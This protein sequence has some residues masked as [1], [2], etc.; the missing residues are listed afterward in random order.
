MPTTTDV[1]WFKTEFG[2]EIAAALAGTPFDLDM[3]TALACQETGY[4]WATLRRKGLARTDIL[5]LCV[6]DTLDRTSTFPRDRAHLKE[7]D[8]NGEVFALA[9]A[10]LVEMARYIPGYAG[11][12]AKP[13]KFCKGF[14]MFQYDMQFLSDKTRAFFLGGYADFGSALARCIEEL[15]GAMKRA[16]IVPASA[17][18]DMDKA[19]IAIAYN[20]GSYDR[21]RG[22]K[23]GYK[24]KDG[25]YYGESYYAYLQ[26]SRSVP[27]TTG[28][29]AFV[30]PDVAVLPPVTPAAVGAPYVVDTREGLLNVR[31]QPKIVRQPSNVLRGL[32]AGHPVNAL[33]GTPTN[34]FLEIETNVQ[35]AYVRGWAAAEFLTPATPAAA[36]EHL[37]EHVAPVAS[38]IP[39]VHLPLKAGTVI[40]RAAP[41]NAGSLN[42]GGQPRRQG[43]TPA[44]LQAS[45]ADII[46]WLAVDDP[47]HK[48]YQPRD[49]LTFCNIYAHDFCLL[50]GVYLPRVWWSPAALLGMARGETVEPRYGATIDELRAN[51]LFRWLR[52]FGPGFGWRQTGTLTKLQLA[53]NSGGV[54]LIVA[55]R[56]EDGKSGHIVA[57]VPETEGDRAKR[58]S[59]GEV[60]AP[61]Q[62]QAGAANFRR[63]TGRQDWWRGDAFAEFSFWIHA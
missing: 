46:D 53:A 47:A 21:A 57:V 22:L 6:G 29:P 48:R 27:V 9:R 11:S 32:P 36:T 5:R 18:S 56:K 34:G 2:P 51:D 42:E 52:D 24:P 49:G 41:A 35:G 3:L 37:S 45:I 43:A 31:A 8:A 13:D 28:A 10:L 38:T 25:P 40:R 60:I 58:N 44:A 55:R 1:K 50:A 39:P 59:A 20:A 15:K 17:L 33:S 14:G 63:G 54:G 19:A 4:I 7:R 62:S 30:A 12:A 16:K 61:L 23:Q 26:L